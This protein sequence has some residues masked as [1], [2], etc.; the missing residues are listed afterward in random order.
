[1]DLKDGLSLLD[2]FQE[3]SANSADKDGIIISIH[4]F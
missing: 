1:M 2:L 3:D 4:L